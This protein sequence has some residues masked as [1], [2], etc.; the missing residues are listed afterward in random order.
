M[1]AT[2]R[3]SDTFASLIEAL[4]QVHASK[5]LLA[6]QL[7]GILSEHS[8]ACCD[9]SRVRG[10][11]LDEQLLAKVLLARS[12]ARTAAMT[13][14][15]VQVE[16]RSSAIACRRVALTVARI[17]K[18]A[19]RPLVASPTSSLP[20]GSAQLDACSPTSRRCDIP[21]LAN[22]AR[23]RLQE[24]LS[25]TASESDRLAAL[26]A[27]DADA[28]A[29]SSK[30][31]RDSR[32]NTWCKIAR[33]WDLPALPLT[34]E[35]VRAVACTLKQ[36]QYRTVEPFF[37]IARQFHRAQ[38]D[39]EPGAAVEYEIT[40]SISSCLR[41]M[42]P[43]RSKD[44][45]ELED[46]RP[47]VRKL[48][49]QQWTCVAGSAQAPSHPSADTATC[50][51][52]S[53]SFPP[54]WWA[55]FRSPASGRSDETRTG[56]ECTFVSPDLRITMDSLMCI[57]GAWFL[58]REIELAAAKFSD[59]EF[60]NQART[61]TWFLPVSKTD[62]TGMGTRRSHGC[63]STSGSRCSEPLCP[64]HCAWFYCELRQALPSTTEPFLF[65]D[66]TGQQLT[67]V[68]SIL[69]IR[70]SLS[71]MRSIHEKGVAPATQTPDEEESDVGGHIL[72]VAGA[73]FLARC[74]LDLYVIQLIGRW[75]SMAV[76]KYVQEA[77]LRRQHLFAFR[78][79]C[80]LQDLNQSDTDLRTRSAAQ[81]SDVAGSAQA[82]STVQQPDHSPLPSAL[83]DCTDDKR[84]A[85]EEEPA[86]NWAA[87]ISQLSDRL[88]KVE[89]GHKPTTAACTLVTNP[90]SR[91]V[92]RPALDETRNDSFCWRT[93]CGWLYAASRY[94]RVSTAPADFRLCDRCFPE[95]RAQD[96]LPD[97]SEI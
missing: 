70:S 20:T 12:A 46:M 84:I 3:Q 64:F 80:G 56:S 95:C 36:G 81:V 13:T 32:W 88:L 73:Q 24:A 60:D 2:A 21:K 91:I 16:H 28:Y 86:A 83:A 48:V 9:E 18:S 39:A 41:G 82:S 68:Q 54:S 11:Q 31:P 59:L 14:S 51:P 23:G 96:E 89:A 10:L 22:K 66:D 19:S 33:H 8:L 44:S 40:K 4:R 26:M 71:T 75:G 45:F 67:K 43:S 53:L 57:L 38:T 50:W 63:A 25:S 58:T 17:D 29:N 52:S 30:K 62:Q 76:A 78:A 27:L 61:I 47:V 79:I 42:G 15:R 93:M 74:G 72:R 85:D 90:I 1:A 65:V 5:A 77:P 34:V 37:S 87:A 6:V 35:L 55:T 92:H 69:S 94:N 49:W 97:S 7:A